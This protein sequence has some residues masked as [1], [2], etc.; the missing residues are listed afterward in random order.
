MREINGNICNYG[1]LWHVTPPKCF[2]IRTNQSNRAYRANRNSINLIY[3]TIAYHVKFDDIAYQSL[4]NDLLLSF[5]SSIFKL[6]PIKQFQLTVDQTSELQSILNIN[7]NQ[8][9]KLQRFV[10]KCTNRILLCNEG[11]LLDF[12]CDNDMITAETLLAVFQVSTQYTSSRSQLPTQQLHVYIVDIRDALS[13]I[14]SSALNYN[15]FCIHHTLSQNEIKVEIG[16]DKSDSGIAESVSAAVVHKHHGKYGSIITTLTDAKVAENYPN[17]RTLSLLKNKR[18]LVNQMLLKPNCIILANISRNDNNVILSKKFVVF[19]MLFTP[20]EQS[21]WNDKLSAELINIDSP[22][23]VILKIDHRQLPDIKK[24]KKEACDLSMTNDKKEI[25]DDIEDDQPVLCVDNNVNVMQDIRDGLMHDSRLWI[26]DAHELDPDARTRHYW[27]CKQILIHFDRIYVVDLPANFTLKYPKSEWNNKILHEIEEE[28]NGWVIKVVQGA[29][30]IVHNESINN[31]IS[32]SDESNESDQDI[33]IQTKKKTNMNDDSDYKPDSAEESPSDHIIK[34]I[35]RKK[36]IILH[37]TVTLTHYALNHFH[38]NASSNLNRM[39]KSKW[40]EDCKYASSKSAQSDTLYF[41]DW[42][43]LTQCKPNKSLCVIPENKPCV[44]LTFDSL[45][46]DHNGIRFF[47][48]PCALLPSN[49]DSMTEYVYTAAIVHNNIVKGIVNCFIDTWEPDDALCKLHPGVRMCEI[50]QRCMAFEEF[51]VTQ[52]IGD[53]SIHELSVKFNTN[54]NEMRLVAANTA[55]FDSALKHVMHGWQMNMN[56]VSQYDN[57]GSHMVDGM[58]QCTAKYFC[59]ICSISNDCAHQLPR[60]STMQFSTR[61]AESKQRNLH[62]GMNANGHV[63]LIDSKGVQNQP[64]Y[65]ISAHRHGAVTLH[66]MEGIW[67]VAMDTFQDQLCPVHGH[68]QQLKNLQSHCKKMDEKYNVITKL[69]D[70]IDATNPNVND[71][72]I[73]HWLMESKTKLNALRTEYNQLEQEWNQMNDTIKDNYHLMEFQSIL[74]KHNISLYYMLPG[75]VQGAV[76]GKLCKAAS[77][78]VDLAFKCNQT[79]GYIWAHYFNNLSFMYDMLKHKSARNWTIHE[80]ASMKTAY[81][82]WYHLHV[83]VVS[84]WRMK[85]SIGAKCHYLMHDIEKSFNNACSPAAE[86]DQRF[87]NSN[88]TVDA[89]LK[90]YTRYKKT[91]KLHL[92]ARKSN[93]RALRKPG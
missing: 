34:P 37:N 58:A 73:R 64:L 50:N 93:T 21:R 62:N 15:Q 2:Q 22:S 91:D 30:Q 83:I 63:N 27:S 53:C 74:K 49:Y 79:G 14:V 29:T 52:C 28:L 8:M 54:L 84:L 17:Y 4:V 67:A 43:S 66:N 12:Q 88:Q 16:C 70:N 80:M 20:E 32:D 3:N 56:G 31:D 47:Y 6:F 1:Y 40:D 51:R 41:I 38:F 7:N 24:I 10:R 18:N 13:R 85:G 71:R 65:N 75:S 26:N 39:A 72:E 42:T 19:P 92:I 36:P 48:I 59:A 77:D 5:K 76:C 90:N 25:E 78:L 57:K 11:A 68:K 44:S 89:G 46:D 55:I 33:N 82:D 60:P 69:Q 61:T 45:W 87:E 35:T 81:I 23:I 9:R 86:D